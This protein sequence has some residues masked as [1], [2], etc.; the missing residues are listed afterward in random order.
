MSLL[1]KIDAYF[2]AKSKNETKAIFYT[3]A[4][5]FAFLIYL[6]FYD[7]SALFLEQS[8]VAYKR[9]ELR[10]K[11]L[12]L[13]MPN[14]NELTQNNKSID[15]LKSLFND[16]NAQNEYFDSK[17][18]ELS[19]LLFD[20]QSWAKFLNQI[21]V[22]AKDSNVNILNLQNNQKSIN[23]NIVSENLKI[24]LELSATYQNL[25]NFINKLESSK[26]VV[27]IS[28]L[29]IS[30]DKNELKASLSLSVWGIKY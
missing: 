16:T 7:S 11:E 6:F 26:L 8:K 13:N 9:S 19:F 25:L 28:K 20:E 17:L 12:N 1:S 3:S 29:N 22:D 15:N 24:E 14:Q 10:T 5:V 18:K 30:S 2:E 23:Q 21:I 27:E 4:I